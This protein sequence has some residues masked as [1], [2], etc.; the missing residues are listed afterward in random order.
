MLLATNAKL[1]KSTDKTRQ[2]LIAGLTLAPHGISGHQVCDEHSVACAAACNMWFSGRRVTGP[3]RKA[4]I[5]KTKWFF[6]DRK[7]FLYALDKDIARHVR[8][9]ERMQVTPAGRLNMGSDLDWTDV[10]SKWP[11]VIWYDYTKIRSRF[12]DYLAGNLPENYYLTFSRHEGH[13]DDTVSKFLLAGGNVA[14]VFNITYF[15]GRTVAPMPPSHKI[16][17]VRF[18]VVSGDEHDLRLPWIDGTGKI[19]GLALKGTNASKKRAIAKGFAMEAEYAT[20]T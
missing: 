5:E 4:A 12:E 16:N 13:T 15:P 9:C 18:P 17:G 7:S 1:K 2:Y 3:A 11:D 20:T 10:I 6:E 8:R 14:Q 19:I